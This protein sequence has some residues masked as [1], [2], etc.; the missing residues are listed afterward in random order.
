MTSAGGSLTGE[1]TIDVS[2]SLTTHFGVM[3][4]SSTTVLLPGATASLGQ[5]YLEES[6]RFVVEGVATFE[7]EDFSM[8]GTSVLDVVGTFKGERGINAAGH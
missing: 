5:T 7:K 1:G 2:G 3:A 4:G 8:S 6:A